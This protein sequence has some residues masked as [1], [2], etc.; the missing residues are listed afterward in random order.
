MLL[1]SKVLETEKNTDLNRHIPVM[2]CDLLSLLLAANSKALLTFDGGPLTT[3]SLC[4]AEQ[5]HS[6]CMWLTSK[7]K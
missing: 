1:L 6:A 5:R 7:P 4:S 2:F 3:T